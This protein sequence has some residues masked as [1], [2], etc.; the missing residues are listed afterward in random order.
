MKN[1]IQGRASV[2]SLDFKGASG[3]EGASFSR[4]I[5][6]MNHLGK[7]STVS[8]NTSHQYEY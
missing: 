6:A 1:I 2:M 4:F 3:R 7:L 8:A 5:V